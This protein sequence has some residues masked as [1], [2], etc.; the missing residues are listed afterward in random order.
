MVDNSNPPHVEHMLDSPIV[1]FDQVP[2]L[3]VHA[4]VVSMTLAVHI[5]EPKTATETKDHIVAVGHLRFPIAALAHLRGALDKVA[6]MV[7]PTTGASN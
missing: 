3:G 5:G 4:G 2:T 6:L 7:A 1:Y